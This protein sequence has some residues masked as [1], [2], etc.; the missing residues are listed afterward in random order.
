MSVLFIMGT[1]LAFFLRQLTFKPKP[2]PAN[3]RLDG[4]TAIVTGA[5]GGLG[6]EAAKEM[7]QH[8]L[9]R[10]IIGVRSSKSGEAAKEQLTALSLS[11]DVQYWLLDHE[12]FSSMAEF[13]TRAKSLDRLDIVIL[14]AGVKNLSFIRSETGHESN[15]QVC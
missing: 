8:G 6:L 9:S 12:S 15:V 10:I 7:V 3:I 13:G 2:L 14:S 1:M 4:K 5:S 11:C